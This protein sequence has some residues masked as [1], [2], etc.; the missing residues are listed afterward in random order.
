MARCGIDDRSGPR[1]PEPPT[2]S[3]RTSR[4]A[5]GGERRVDP[6]AYRENSSIRSVK[7]KVVHWR[8][9]RRPGA[10]DGLEEQPEDDCPGERSEWNPTSSAA[11]DLRR[12][13]MS[14]KVLV[15]ACGKLAASLARVRVSS[16]DIEGCAR[17]S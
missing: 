12:S 6:A 4:P 11:L 8:G 3:R 17:R 5:S 15:E 7:Q 1:A 16:I 9:G 10:L 2:Q 13:G 14:R